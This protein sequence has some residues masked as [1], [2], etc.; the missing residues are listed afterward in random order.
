MAFYEPPSFGVSIH[1]NQLPNQ[2][3]L[4][5]YGTD[6]LQGIQAGLIFALCWSSQC[7]QIILGRIY[8]PK[9]ANLASNRVF[10]NHI[11]VDTHTIEIILARPG[12]V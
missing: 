9:P 7:A 1:V 4:Q 8:A 11:S 5:G 6:C 10:P 12:V 2:I 3:Q